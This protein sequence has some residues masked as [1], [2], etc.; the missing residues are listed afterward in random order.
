MML[1]F[2]VVHIFF[3]GT[4]GKNRQVNV[5]DYVKEIVTFEDAYAVDR[6]FKLTTERFEIPLLENM[7]KVRR[8]VQ[9]SL[10]RSVNGVQLAQV[11]KRIFSSENT[12]RYLLGNGISSLP[13]D[14]ELLREFVYSKRRNKVRNDL[15]LY[16]DVELKETV[17]CEKD[18]Y[19]RHRNLYLT[20]EL[21]KTGFVEGDLTNVSFFEILCS[22]AIDR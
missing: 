13:Y 5:K 18:I 15:E 1:F 17:K 2:N 3:V 4:S 19:K 12:K 10:K 11:K 6:V 20:N 22:Y 7:N 16:Q 14:H 9:N 8:V 21:F